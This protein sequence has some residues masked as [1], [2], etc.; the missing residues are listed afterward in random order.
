MMVPKSIEFRRR[1]RRGFNLVELLIALAISATL[2]TATMLALA[3]S[4]MAYQSTTEVASTH[5]LS[6][7]TL[8]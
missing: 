3:A 2:L 8:H 7:P 6:R 4:F 1:R 5:T